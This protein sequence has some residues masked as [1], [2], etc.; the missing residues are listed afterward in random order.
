M[1]SDVHLLKNTAL[2]QEHVIL[3]YVLGPRDLNGA[4]APVS[5]SLRKLAP[6]ALVDLLGPLTRI[7][8]DAPRLMAR[9]MELA[10]Q[11]R[12]LRFFYCKTSAAMA[13]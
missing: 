1:F 10:R 12:L 7:V 4:Y 5:L 2:S 13:R 8:G 3:N 9:H 11:A 6:E